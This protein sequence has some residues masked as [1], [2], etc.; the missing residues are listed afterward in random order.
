MYFYEEESSFD[1]FKHEAF[2]LTK[3]HST[4]S[5]AIFRQQASMFK[6]LWIIEKHFAEIWQ[7]SLSHS[8][9]EVFKL[10]IFLHCN[11]VWK[12]YSRESE[13]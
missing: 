2:G 7:K 3:R 12:G 6:G 4:F 8:L 11:P 10:L 9:N 13:H 5:H 1:V